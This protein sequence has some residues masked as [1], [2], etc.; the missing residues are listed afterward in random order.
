MPRSFR[1]YEVQRKIGSGGMSTLYLGIQKALNREVAIKML[2]PGLAEDE[3][4]IGRFEREAKAASAIGHRNIVS[5]IDFGS[6]EDIYYIVMELVQ[7]MDMK[8]ALDKTEKIPPEIVLPVLEEIS[9]GLEAAHDQGIIHRDI[10]PGNIM[11]SNGGEIKVADFG[12]ARQSSDIAR[13]S[14]LTLP[15]SV[16][17]TPAYMSPEQAAGKEVDHRTDIF[18][19]GVMAYELLTGKKPFPGSSYSE[20]RD[21]LINSDPE[22]ISL[23]AAVTPEIE[24]LVGRMIAKDP[25]R[26]FPS[27]RHVIRHLED[28]METL[29]PSGGLIKYRRKYLGKF[30][31][32]PSGFSE[33]LRRSSVSSHLDRG[34]YFKKMGMAKIDDAVREFR[35]VLF[36]DPD[37]SKAQTAIRDIEEEAE[38]SGVRMPDGSVPTARK[39]V[40]PEEDSTPT[41]VAEGPVGG[42]TRVLPGAAAPGGGPGATQVLDPGRSGTSPSGSTSSSAGSGGRKWILP[43]G[44]AVIALVLPPVGF[45]IALYGILAKPRTQLR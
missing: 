19:L 20:I 38:E 30:A 43:A 36:I 21:K 10:K 13:I 1:G 24:A 29:D 27:V 16:L 45:F 3:Q 42:V 31:A 5:V 41:A 39:G 23:S 28:C 9:Y 35:Y 18:S 44:L 2:H 11:I 25:D 40:A 15:G 32:D 26:R 17:G 14:A 37:N 7:G 33:E 4:F 12:L 6:E 34:Y 22:P 8:D